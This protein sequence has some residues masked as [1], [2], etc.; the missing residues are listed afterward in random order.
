M[1]SN[2]VSRAHDVSDGDEY[3]V[4]GG[5]HGVPRDVTTAA[6]Q[7]CDDVTASMESIE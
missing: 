7:S 1:F 3:D 6:G 4:I 2:S 5:F